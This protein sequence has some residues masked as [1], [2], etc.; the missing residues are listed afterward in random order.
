MKGAVEKWLMVDEKEVVTY[1]FHHEKDFN[2]WA[3]Q[4]Q[5]RWEERPD[6]R[7]VE[8]EYFNKTQSRCKLYRLTRMEFVG[9]LI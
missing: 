3:I 5:R 4:T 7:K 2:Q 6:C 8:E 1:I 9:I